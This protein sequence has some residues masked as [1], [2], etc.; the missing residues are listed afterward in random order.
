MILSMKWVL[1]SN[2]TDSIAES[3]DLLV[4]VLVSIGGA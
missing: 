1:G 4:L 2:F 3:V